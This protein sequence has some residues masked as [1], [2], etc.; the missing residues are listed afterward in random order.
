MAN[1]VRIPVA[2]RGLFMGAVFKE[3]RG[4]KKGKNVGR[5]LVQRDGELPE[6]V[7]VSQWPENTGLTQNSPVVFEATIGFWS[8]EG[9]S[10]LFITFDRFINGSEKTAKVTA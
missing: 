5:V 10:G 2:I 8:M 6:T 9:R 3:G 7:D 4:D 1:G